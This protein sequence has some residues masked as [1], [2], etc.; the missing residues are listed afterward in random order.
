MTHPDDDPVSV[1]AQRKIDDIVAQGPGGAF[2]V[3]GVATVIVIGMFVLFYLLV[4]LPRGA[5]Q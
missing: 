3:A 4:Y 1:D 5:V 2:A